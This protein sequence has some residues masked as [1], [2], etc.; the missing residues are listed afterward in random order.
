M[1]IE[2]KTPMRTFILIKAYMSRVRRIHQGKEQ[3]EDPEQAVAVENG[4]DE[5]NGGHLE[6]DLNILNGN[7]GNHGNPQANKRQEEEDDEDLMELMYSTE[8]RA[9][10]RRDQPIE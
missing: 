1:D 10:N 9:G 2:R 5:G 3:W 4:E 6:H 7:H 8:K